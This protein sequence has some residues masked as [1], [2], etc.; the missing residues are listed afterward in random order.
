MSTSRGLANQT[1]YLAR[2]QLAAWQRA[3]DEQV[4][5]VRT[6]AQAFAPAVRSHLLDAYGWFLLT[7][8]GVPDIPSRPPSC[9]AE[10]P[11]VPV[12][13]SLP[14]EIHELVQVERGGWIGE[15]QAELP[16]P[17][18]GAVSPGNLLACGPELPDLA[19]MTAWANALEALFDRMGD[20]LDEY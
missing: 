14:G 19:T 20:S 1:L 17:A 7:I 18:V 11:P 4:I 13:K 5:P 6:L 12:G 15:M 9:C 2:I 8:I 16:P 3:L 10:L